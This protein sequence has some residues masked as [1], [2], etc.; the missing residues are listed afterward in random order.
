[1]FDFL[2]RSKSKMIDSAVVAWLNSQARTTQRQYKTIVQSWREHLRGIDMAD[3]KELHA[4]GFIAEQGKQKNRYGR[5][6]SRATAH[7]KG[8][9]LRSLY[10]A[11]RADG[12][13]SHNPFSRLDLDATPDGTRSPHRALSADEVRTLLKTNLPDST[14]ED[15]LIN[16]A[17]I[18]LLFAQGLRIS[19]ACALTLDAIEIASPSPILRLESTK[20]GRS[21]VLPIP[22]WAVG[23]VQALIKHRL[24]HPADTLLGKSVETMRRR[25]AALIREANLPHATVHSARATA[26]THLLASGMDYRTVQEFSRHSSVSM[27]EAYDKRRFEIDQHPAKKIKY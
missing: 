8:L 19:E 12:L 11:L 15:R 6:V 7:R 17:F 13:V 24:A 25:F 21:Y 23:P 10:E 20:N 2:F 27:V 1:M 5:K 4:R 3:A 26:I 16:Q 9:I 14:D 18:T 22:D